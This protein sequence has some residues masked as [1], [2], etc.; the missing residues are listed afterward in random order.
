MLDYAEAG[1]YVGLDVHSQKT[2]IKAIAPDRSA[3]LETTIA[4]E[5]TKLRKALRSLPKPIWVMAESG[6]MTGYIVTALQKAVDRVVICET[7]ENR[8]I[9]MSEDKGDPQDA[10]RLARLLRMGEFK[11]V[12]VPG[13][14]RYALRELMSAYHKN[15]ADGVRIKNRIKAVYRKNAIPATGSV[16]FTKHGREQWLKKLKVPC[17]RFMQESQYEQMD[18]VETNQRKLLGK[19]DRELRRTKEYGLLKTIPGVGTVT[20]AIFITVI[21]D[22]FRF[23]TKRKLWKY[24]GLS[25]RSTWSSNPDTAHKGGSPSGN[26]L[27]KYGAMMASVNALRGDNRFTR[28]YANMRASGIATGMAKRTIARQILAV[29]WAMWKT[30]TP[31]N[32]ACGTIK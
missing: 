8:W 10:D 3:L 19:L 5:S 16:L 29:A 4:T 32:D 11:E 15:V 28:H 1:S 17:T 27:L 26:R 24:A 30:G 20:A 6:C 14:K 12:H 2:A 25:V 18:A 9:S 23:S 22:P 31:Y 7:R 21:D 13:P